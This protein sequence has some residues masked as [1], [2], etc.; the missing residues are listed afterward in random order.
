[1]IASAS[2][3]ST[4][5]TASAERIQLSEVI[6]QFKASYLFKPLYLL[7]RCRGIQR[8]PAC[9]VLQFNLFYQVCQ[10]HIIS[11]SDLRYTFCSIAT[12]GFLSVL[13]QGTG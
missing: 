4:S 1:M 5:H 10:C 8:D 12:T 7:S 11:F 3:L 9:T 2:L 6:R 13:T